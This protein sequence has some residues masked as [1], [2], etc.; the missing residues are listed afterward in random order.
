MAIFEISWNTL[1]RLWSV[2]H[3]NYLLH[4]L[5]ELFESSRNLATCSFYAKIDFNACFR[6]T[7]WRRYASHPTARFERPNHRTNHHN[8]LQNRWAA[9]SE[10]SVQSSANSQGIFQ[11]AS[12]SPHQKPTDGCF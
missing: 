6:G 10:R 11:C 4:Y 5:R 12:L 3:I 1:S 9:E 2:L 8:S 7:F